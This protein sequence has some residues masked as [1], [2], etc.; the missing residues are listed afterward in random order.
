MIKNFL[1][2]ILF[3]DIEK[4]IWKPISKREQIL[5]WLN[6][7]KPLSQRIREYNRN[8]YI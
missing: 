1:W 8:T 7:R 5:K 2:K 4:L 3:Y 6:S